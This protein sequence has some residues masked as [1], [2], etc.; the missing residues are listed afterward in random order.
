MGWKTFSMT[1]NSPPPL[2]KDIEA[3]CCDIAA[4]EGCRNAKLD[5]IKRG[6][7]DRVYFLPRSQ[8][9][10]VE[11]KRPG[12]KPRPQQTARH[13]DFA[14]L[15]HIVDVVETVAQFEFLLSKRLEAIAR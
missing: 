14:K 6:D 4:S 11:F 9:W 15:G 5:K 12:E 7:P 1:S 8:C 2:E 3:E 10:L 13:E